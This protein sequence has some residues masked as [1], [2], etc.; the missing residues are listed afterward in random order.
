MPDHLSLVARRIEEV[1]EAKKLSRQQLADLLDTREDRWTYLRVYRI[2]TGA[3]GVS[4]EDV[5]R[6]AEVLDASVTS[7]YRESKAS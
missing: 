1:R 3:T 7:F 5:L 6:I 2:E 4:A